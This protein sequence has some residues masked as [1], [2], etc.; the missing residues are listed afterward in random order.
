M[1]SLPQ[2]SPAQQQIIRALSQGIQL[3]RLRTALKSAV[4]QPAAL[5]T[6]VWCNTSASPCPITFF[7]K[8]EGEKAI[9]HGKERLS[10]IT[11]PWST[12]RQVSVLSKHL[13]GTASKQHFYPAMRFPQ[14]P[15]KSCKGSAKSSPPL[16][17]AACC[18]TCPKP[19]EVLA[20]LYWHCPGGEINAFWKELA[21]HWASSK[22]HSYENYCW[23][24]ESVR[25]G[26][27]SARH[28]TILIHLHWDVASE[29]GDERDL[30]SL[31]SRDFDFDL[32]LSCEA[33]VGFCRSHPDVYVR[34]FTLSEENLDI[35]L[36]FANTGA[37]DLSCQGAA[38]LHHAASP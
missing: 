23:P 17:P 14:Q 24:N 29:R 13:S 19:A 9:T 38:M 20:H 30:N 8:A 16:L 27:G 35:Y 25:D 11:E 18:H 21:F 3:Q 31:L 6:K 36:S 4:S 28:S 37:G 5:T 33:W 34:L 12:G 26:N 22:V 7:Q 15:K 1:E 2:P 10:R 32:L